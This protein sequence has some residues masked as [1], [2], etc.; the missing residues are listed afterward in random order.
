[1]MII[2]LNKNNLLNGLKKI[3]KIIPQ[4]KTLKFFNQVHISFNND[5][6]YILGINYNMTAKFKISESKVQEIKYV[7]LDYDNLLRILESCCS[8]LISLNI[9]FETNII[10][11]EDL[12]NRTN[13]FNVVIPF[14][15][16]DLSSYDFDILDYKN[17]IQI[18]ECRLKE[19][20]NQVIYA[21][22]KTDIKSSLTGVLFD[23]SESLLKLVACDGKR[24]CI[25]K[26]VIESI[27]NN[28]LNSIIR[29]DSL[30]RMKNI[31]TNKANNFTNIYSDDDKIIFELSNGY[32]IKVNMLPE[33][34]IDY[35]DII[36]QNILKPIKTTASIKKKE[37]LDCL[38]KCS[39]FIN[40]RNRSP[41]KITMVNKEIII[42]IKSDLGE[43]S[44]VL[45]EYYGADLQVGINCKFLLDVVKSINSDYIYMDFVSPYSMIKIFSPN[46]DFEAG[47]MPIKLKTY[48][49]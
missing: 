41:L 45:G 8:N 21:T 33:Q 34:Y 16:S 43:F 12:E 39:T 4:R 23:Y 7:S 13:H 27:N 42:S 18:E 22:A 11:V 6:I 40:V 29:Y 46:D 10:K 25:S 1:M 44:D 32:E 9:D 14:D 24:I 5:G 31:F 20:I 37:L 17:I 48:D 3:K 49:I 26:E 35:N 19:M 15:L 28:N 30:R 2:N 38:K 47:I 36:N